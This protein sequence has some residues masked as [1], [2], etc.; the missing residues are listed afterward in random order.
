MGKGMGDPVN[1]KP[2]PYLNN[3]QNYENW[4]MVPHA[5]TIDPATFAR[6]NHTQQGA[7]YSSTKSQEHV[8]NDYAS[9]RDY[10]R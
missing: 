5:R 1:L 2:P 10:Y 3:G 7:P 9:F 4:E 6:I 8:F